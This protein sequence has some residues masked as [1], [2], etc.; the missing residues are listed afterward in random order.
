MDIKDVGDALHE[1]TKTLS[2]DVISSCNKSAL[3]TIDA[4]GNFYHSNGTCISHMNIL[5]MLDDNIAYKRDLANKLH[6]IGQHI[7]KLDKDYDENLL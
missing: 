1:I 6:E 3:I 5:K 7:Q 4:K 2:Y